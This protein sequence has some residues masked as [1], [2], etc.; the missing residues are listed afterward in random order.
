[1]DGERS[2]DLELGFAAGVHGA[3]NPRRHETD[4]GKPG[5]LQDVL[6]HPFIASAAAAIAAGGVDDDFSGG[7]AGGR[8]ETNRPAL[9]PE[10][11]VNGMQ[12]VAQ[13][14]CGVAFGGGDVEHGLSLRVADQN[15]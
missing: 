8:I 4:L 1:M 15:G 5:A 13:S 6:M 3:A 7:C 12:H 10:C 14:E 9:Y 11:S 2:V